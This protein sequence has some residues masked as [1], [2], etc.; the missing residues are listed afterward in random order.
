MLPANLRMTTI[1]ISLMPMA[2]REYKLQR[3]LAGVLDRYEFIVMDA[4]PSFGLLN[5]NALMASDDLL[6]PVLPGFPV[7]SRSQ[8]AVRDAGPA[9]GRPEPPAAAD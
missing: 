1:D 4:P 2:G 7:V 8:I 5:L 3:A 6:V 9:R